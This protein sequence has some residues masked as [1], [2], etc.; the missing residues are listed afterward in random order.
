MV[1]T[2]EEIKDAIDKTCINAHEIANAASLTDTQGMKATARALYILSIEEYGKI[3]WLYWALSLKESDDEGWRLFWKA[4]RSHALKNEIGRRMAR[5]LS[6]EGLLPRL[7]NFFE[8]HFPFFAVTP[9]T[10]DRLKQAMLYVDFDHKKRKFVGP[11]DRAGGREI[12]NGDFFE[13]IWRLIRYIAY[14]REHYVFDLGVM[15]AFRKLNY[16]AQNVRHLAALIRLFYSCVLHH[17]TSM[18]QEKSLRDIVEE[19]RSE[20]GMAPDALVEELSKL[21]EELRQGC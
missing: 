14:N 9:G 10:L 20:H 21:G 4:F 15:T 18:V 13:E 5:H 7:S 6:T 12:D 19:L 3:G 17:P 8:L 11:I 1:L 2:P 16:Q